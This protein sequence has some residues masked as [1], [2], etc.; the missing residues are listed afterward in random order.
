MDI[1]PTRQNLNGLEPNNRPKE[2][3]QPT[4]TGADDTNTI[5]AQ[6]SDT[7]T[8]T[9]TATRIRELEATLGSLPEIDNERVAAIRQAI[10]DGSYQVDPENIAAKLLKLEQELL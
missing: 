6:P 7:V 2:Q 5:G 3:S 9:D 4:K 1:K 10:A 8:V